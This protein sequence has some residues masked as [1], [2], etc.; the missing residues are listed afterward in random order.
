MF[1]FSVQKVLLNEEREDGQPL[2][3][4]WMFSISFSI[5][6]L[7]DG[8]SCNF[9]CSLSLEDTWLGKSPR[10]SRFPCLY[11]LSC[12]RLRFVAFILPSLGYLSCVLFWPFLVE[13]KGYSF[14]APDPF[15][16]FLVDLFSVFCVTPL[17]PVPLF[18]HIVKG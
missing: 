13:G 8:A 16:G 2:T 10:C 3:V 1:E 17:L 11:H 4:G 7:N 12:I 6:T 18:F 9:F 15:K 14:L 5:N